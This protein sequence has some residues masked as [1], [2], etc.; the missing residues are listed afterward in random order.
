MATKFSA[1]PGGLDLFVTLPSTGF[2]QSTS[3]I[4]PLFMRTVLG[5]FHASLQDST[6]GAVTCE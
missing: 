4:A 6:I 5:Y 2:A 1:V 3:K